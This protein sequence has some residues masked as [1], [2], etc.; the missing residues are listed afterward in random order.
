MAVRNPLEHVKAIISDKVAAAYEKCVQDGVLPR[1]ELADFEVEVPKDVSNGDFSVNFA[2][3]N[4]KLL[5]KAPALIGNEIV[6]R[7]DKGGLIDSVSVAYPGFINFVLS[8][9]YYSQQVDNIL[10]LGGEFGKTDCLHG[11]K[12]LVE[13]VSANPTGTYAYGQCARRHYRRLFSVGSELCGE[14]MFRASFTSMTQAIRYPL[15][16]QSLYARLYQLKNGEDSMEFPDDGYHGDDIR[17]LARE[18]AQ[19]HEEISFEDKPALV[20]SLVAFGLK[21]T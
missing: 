3:K 8:S 18:Y 16:G 10:E 17:E 19:Q 14:P 7:L 6:S 11:E 9:Q 20:N 5:K 15:F 12:I 1:A 2:M 21:R 13:F 4:V